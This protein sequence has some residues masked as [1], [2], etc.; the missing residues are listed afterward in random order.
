MS[1]SPASLAPTLPPTACKAWAQ[2]THHAES[3]SAVHL[4]DLFS[5]DVARS[6]QF[7]AEGAGL[8]YD[9]SRQRMGA[10]TL[11]LMARLA[12]ERGFAEWRAA[13]L[14]GKPVNDTENRPAWHT[15]LRAG[16]SS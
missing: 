11:R 2:L 10:M 3:W 15:A 12:E 8:R 16:R 7:V 4:R 5:N 13:L 6:T 1:G 14:G 9:F